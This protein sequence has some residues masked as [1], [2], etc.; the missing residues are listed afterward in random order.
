L[1]EGSPS[2][3]AKLQEKRGV[4]SICLN[5]MICSSPKLLHLI[6][7]SEVGGASELM[8]KEFTDR[9]Y[10]DMTAAKLA[11][12]PTVPCVS[13][14]TVLRQFGIRHVAI[15]S[16]DVEGAEISVLRTID[17]FEFSASFIIMDTR[18]GMANDAGEELQRVG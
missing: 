8:T 6:E 5:A 2:L 14:T 3:Y 9:F 17:W 10:P 15:F 1:I 7:R 18:E 4:N 16:L 13:L 11:T 12:M